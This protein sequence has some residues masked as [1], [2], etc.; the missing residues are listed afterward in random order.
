MS[1]RHPLDLIEVQSPCK[2]DWEK[3]SGSQRQRYCE[4]C[5]LHVYDLTSLNE[6]EAQALICRE[7]GRMCVRFARLPDG[8]VATADRMAQ[9]N[10]QPGSERRRFSWRSWGL[11]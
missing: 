2:M 4:H 3:L 5:H 10:Y 9:L 6:D 11:L 8:R 1:T 7:A